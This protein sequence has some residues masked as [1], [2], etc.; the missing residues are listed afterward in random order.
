MAESAADRRLE[1][2]RGWLLVLAIVLCLG[3][4]RTIGEFGSGLPDFIRGWRANESARGPM[5]V[6]IVL[7]A[8]Y[9]IANLWAVI[10]LFQKSRKFKTAF[11]VLWILAALTPA[12]ALLM[13]GV[14]GVTLEMILPTDEIARATA[15]VI[16]MGLWFWYL[17]ASQ[18]VKNTLVH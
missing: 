15:A 6:V 8:A 11:V 14:R 7:S 10:A 5:A 18:R 12:S 9:L 17:C 1:G 2:I 4:L 13:L 16:G 3:L